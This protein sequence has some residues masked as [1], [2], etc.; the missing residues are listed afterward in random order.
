M[1]YF[2][3]V[4]QHDLVVYGLH[5]FLSKNSYTEQTEYE[6][7]KQMNRNITTRMDRQ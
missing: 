2:M 3:W 5:F 6:N 4:N 7:N 1:K